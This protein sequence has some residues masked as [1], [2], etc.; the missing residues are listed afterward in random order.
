MPNI[1]N[2]AVRRS[3]YGK[4]SFGPFDFDCYLLHLLAFIGI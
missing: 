2:A 3:E 4:N 1:R